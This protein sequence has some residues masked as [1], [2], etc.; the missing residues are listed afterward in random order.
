MTEK[1]LMAKRI[2]HYEKVLKKIYKWLDDEIDHAQDRIDKVDVY[3]VKTNWMF[4]KDALKS[5]KT[6]LSAIERE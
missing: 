4:Y 5:T 3:S 6:R 1:E 2:E